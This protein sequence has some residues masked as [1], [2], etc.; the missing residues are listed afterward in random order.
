[1]N[2]IEVLL[3][4]PKDFFIFNEDR[5]KAYIMGYNH[6]NIDFLPQISFDAN[7]VQTDT[8]QPTIFYTVYMNNTEKGKLASLFNTEFRN[9]WQTKE[10]FIGMNSKTK[11]VVGSNEY[12]FK[13]KD[14][15]VFTVYD[16]KAT[17]LYDERYPDPDAL[18]CSEFKHSFHIGGN[19]DVSDFVH[20]LLKKVNE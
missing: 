4:D 8:E 7:G 15:D 16:W 14:G 3:P 10:C 2:L 12:I 5:Q 13:G 20:W 19:G 18:W 9:I 1:M 6:I 11:R 17:F